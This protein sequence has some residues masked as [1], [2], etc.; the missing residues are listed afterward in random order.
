MKSEIHNKTC[1]VAATT[2]ATIAVAAAAAEKTIKAVQ[3]IWESI[4]DY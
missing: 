1:N 3:T 4:S 2:I